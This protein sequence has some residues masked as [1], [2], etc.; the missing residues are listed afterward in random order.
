M[1]SY[2]LYRAYHS[3]RFVLFTLVR[4]GMRSNLPLTLRYQL[5]VVFEAIRLQT[6]ARLDDLVL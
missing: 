1:S 4:N 3:L 5:R 6:P 2:V